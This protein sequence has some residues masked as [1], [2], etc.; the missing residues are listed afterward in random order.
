MIR[1][2]NRV[3]R[4]PCA[5]RRGQRDEAASTADELRPV[6][7][8][9]RLGARFIGSPRHGGCRTAPGDRWRNG[10]SRLTMGGV[11]GMRQQRWDF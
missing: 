1:E 5:A 3:A 7:Y 8:V 2:T 11:L 10:K 4:D 9:A 6:G